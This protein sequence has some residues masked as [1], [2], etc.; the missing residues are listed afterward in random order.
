[1]CDG[2]DRVCVCVCVFMYINMYV[3]VFM[4]LVIF[5]VNFVLVSL[6]FNGFGKKLTV[7]VQKNI[8][9]N[10]KVENEHLLIA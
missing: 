7:S 1:M 10:K 2:K 9:K 6:F 5:R 4:W 3:C 8:L